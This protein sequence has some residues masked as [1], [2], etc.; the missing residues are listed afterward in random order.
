[1]VINYSWNIWITIYL[2]NFDYKKGG[3]VVQNDDPRCT[4]FVI[5]AIP[6]ESVLIDF[7]Y[8]KHQFVVYKEVF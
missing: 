8:D 2:Y 4:H 1:M 7:D 3:Y 6:G 5:D